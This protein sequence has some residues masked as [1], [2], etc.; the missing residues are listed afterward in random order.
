MKMV[1]GWGKWPITSE[2]NDS[3]KC[4]HTWRHFRSKLSNTSPFRSFSRTYRS[5]TVI[6]IWFWFS[7]SGWDT[8]KGSLSAP[9]NKDKTFTFD[10]DLFN[11]MSF[12]FLEWKSS[13]N[14]TIVSF[15]F[16]RRPFPIDHYVTFLWFNTLAR[17]WLSI[18]WWKFCVQRILCRVSIR[19]WFGILFLFC[20]L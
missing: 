2:P 8:M 3:V 12:D 7:S 10:D 15:W 1:E 9:R 18:T 16:S 11:M 13:E 4:Q 20:L 6:I 17:I 14:Y 5:V 19:L